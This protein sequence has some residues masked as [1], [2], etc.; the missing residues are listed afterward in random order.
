M[1][2]VAFYAGSGGRGIDE[3]EIEMRI[4][5]YQDRL[6]TTLILDSIAYRF[7]DFR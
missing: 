6:A 1:K 5:S 4:V 3:L 2:R 7:E